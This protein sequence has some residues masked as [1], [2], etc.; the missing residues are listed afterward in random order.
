MLLP[1]TDLGRSKG[2]QSRPFSKIAFWVFVANLIILMLLGACHVESP[3][4]KFGQIST[5]FYFSYFIIIM[6]LISFL[7][8]YLVD[9]NL[10]NKEKKNMDFRFTSK[11]REFTVKD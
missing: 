3:F 10:A 4:I 7:E 9:L 6:P 2:F 8:K 1:I 5:A 11:Q